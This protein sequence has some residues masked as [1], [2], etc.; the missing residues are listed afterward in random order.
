MVAAA[1]ALHCA[2]R[3]RVN[4]G[5]G[6]ALRNSRV[7]RSDAPTLAPALELALS[8]PRRPTRR[9]DV[10]RGNTRRI[11]APARHGVYSVSERAMEPRLPASATCNAQWIP[12]DYFFG[13]PYIPVIEA[14]PSALALIME[15]AVDAFASF[16]TPSLSTLSA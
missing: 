13:R 4:A 5:G 7:A 10:T 1:G 12:V 3:H 11:A 16:G 8:A 15:P 9:V 6:S 2:L 14:L